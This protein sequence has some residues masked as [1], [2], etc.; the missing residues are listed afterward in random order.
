MAA[1]AKQNSAQKV[2][3]KHWLALCGVMLGAFMAVLDIQITNSSLN[4]ISGALGSSITEGSWISTAYL[5]AE[6]VAI[7]ISGIMAKIFSL[8]RYLI[9]S[10]TGFLI[11]SVL[12]AFA[13]N[14]NMMILFR[15][16][17]GITG[18]ALI[19]LAF[20][21][22]LTLLPPAKQ[23]IGMAIFG[24]TATFGPSIG[25]T[26]GGWL[27]DNYG[28][29]WIFYIN[30]A[31]GLVMLAII[32][33]CLEEEPM[34]LYL[35]KNL[36][37]FGI[38]TMAIGLGSFVYVLEEGERKDWFGNPTIVDFAWIAGIFIVLFFIRELTAKNPFLQLEV[39][40]HRSFTF[41]VVI[42]T[43]LGLGLYGTVY[44]VP[45]YLAQVQHY[46]ALQIGETLMWVGIPQL[47]IIPFIPKL[48]HR[49]DVRMII[50]IGLVLF[51]ISCLMDAFMDRNFAMNQFR[52][53][54]IVRALGQPLILIPLLSVSTAGLPKNEIGSAS[55]IFNMM[56]N[57]GGS[58]GIALLSTLVT[59][60]EQFHS[61][62]IGETVT[63]LTPQVVAR[64]SSLDSMLRGKGLDRTTAHGTAL[65]I[66][67]GQV[68]TQSLIMAYSEAFYVVGLILLATLGALFFLPKLAKTD[69]ASPAG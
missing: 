62:R 65:T 59:R 31:P 61:V 36:D 40:R 29:Q 10:A 1:K 24:V 19:P 57:L 5:V 25:P 32:W 37:Y 67:N 49:V 50:G 2:S 6:I 52:A 51:G 30:I 23:S 8:K 56:R 35:L 42:M 4:D 15:A 63:L 48:I 45:L 3:G 7:G 11:F 41:A 55:A 33:L 28:W 43:V 44:L 34:D 12:C 9:F 68:Q 16:C 69:G 53:S 54:N 47:F 39:F 46:S 17:Q 27:T 58:I 20:N 64:I 60:R 66:L 21:V 14:L 22:I 18:G 13:N 38:V 26:I